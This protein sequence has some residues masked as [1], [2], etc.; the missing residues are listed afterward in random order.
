MKIPLTIINIK[1]LTSI[2]LFFIK[3]PNRFCW[4]TRVATVPTGRV[5][6]CE[7]MF[8]KIMDIIGIFNG[9][10]TCW[11]VFVFFFNGF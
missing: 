6:S 1:L 5:A 2:A 10:W 11:N 3:G 9:R 7:S 4:D 8:L